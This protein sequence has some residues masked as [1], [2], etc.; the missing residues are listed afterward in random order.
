M[1][2]SGGTPTGTTAADSDGTSSTGAMSSSDTM[3]SSSSGAPPDDTYPPCIMEECEVLGAVCIPLMSS[4]LC[5]PPCV[6]GGGKARGCPSPLSG[7]A[8]PN[9]IEVVQGSN[10][11]HC[12][13]VCSDIAPCPNGMVCDRIDGDSGICGWE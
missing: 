5:A 4:S 7:S 6:L 12:I 9:C 3:G 2:T 1:T 10:E 13:L 11:T 8:I